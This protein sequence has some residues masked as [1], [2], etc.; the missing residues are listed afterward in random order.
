MTSAR[1]AFSLEAIRV[2]N[3]SP[4]EEKST[5]TRPRKGFDLSQRRKESTKERIRNFVQVKKG[6]KESVCAR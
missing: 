1:E 5:K 4:K 6:K 3:L 2:N